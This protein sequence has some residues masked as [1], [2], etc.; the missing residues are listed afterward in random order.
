MPDTL[1][2][3]IRIAAKPETVFRYLT[4]S[5]ALSEWMG[6]SAELEP[7]P[8]GQFLVRYESGDTA[9]GEFSVVEPYTRV[10][11]TWGWK[12]NAGIPPGSSSVE[13]TLAEDEGD[14]LLN[15]RHSGLPHADALKEHGEGWDHF[16]AG[17]ATCAA[18]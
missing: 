11:F 15:L 17:L 12:D 4:D 18:A 5:D 7:T 2:R 16:L 3:E 14:T 10:V 1:E 13:I 6:D 9:L 8:G